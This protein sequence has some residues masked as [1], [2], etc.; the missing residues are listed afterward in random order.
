MIIDGCYNFSFNKQHISKIFF[1]SA[2]DYT[3]GTSESISTTRPIHEIFK[4][5]VQALF[6]DPEKTCMSEQI[7]ELEWQRTQSVPPHALNRKW[8]VLLC[9]VTTN[10]EPAAL[11]TATPSSSYPHQAQ[12]TNSMFAEPL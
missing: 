3:S 5:W 4:P 7:L 10:R 2:E 8:K 6:V 11:E 9:R 12:G 1:S